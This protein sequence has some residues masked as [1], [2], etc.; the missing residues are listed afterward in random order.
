MNEDELPF[1]VFSP[2]EVM[3]CRA[4]LDSVI[5]Q[6]SGTHTLLA[7]A[8]NGEASAASSCL[9]IKIGWTFGWLETQWE[10][11]GRAEKRGLGDGGDGRAGAL[12]A[13]CSPSSLPPSPLP[14]R[15]HHTDPPTRP[16]QEGPAG[17]SPPP[18]PALATVSPQ[19]WGSIKGRAGGSGIPT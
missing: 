2:P 5:D 3:E 9:I 6:D 17:A 16:G 19:T 18:P 12:S 1:P 8:R 13:V 4:T 7:Y 10:R 14:F 15:F 11:A